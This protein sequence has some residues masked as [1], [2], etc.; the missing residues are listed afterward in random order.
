MSGRNRAGGY[1]R[2]PHRQGANQVCQICGEPRRAGD[3]A[4]HRDCEQRAQEELDA[5]IPTR[6]QPRPAQEAHP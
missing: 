2:I 4:R 3:W 5:L 6:G 1:R